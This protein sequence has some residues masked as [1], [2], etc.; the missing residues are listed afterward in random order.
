MFR[1]DSEAVYAQ[2][3]VFEL[4]RRA[5]AL[6]KAGKIGTL[7]AEADRFWI[8]ESEWDPHGSRVRVSVRRLKEIVEGLERKPRGSPE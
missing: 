8:S 6:R 3:E 4:V 5:V 2:E 7:W 1:E